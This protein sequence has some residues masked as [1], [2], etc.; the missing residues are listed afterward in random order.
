MRKKLIGLVFTVCL[1][2]SACTAKN[3]SEQ[4]QS[5]DL[6]QA[7]QLE[8]QTVQET[9]NDSQSYWGT[10]AHNFAKGEGGYY[11][12]DNGDSYL[13]FLMKKHRKAIRYVPCR[14]VSIIRQTAMR[15]LEHKKVP[16]I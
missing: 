2:C 15:M 7:K 5:S 3:Q 6:N 16:D 13:M 8:I 4:P 1:M 12:M 14:I 11:Y 9:E 10:V